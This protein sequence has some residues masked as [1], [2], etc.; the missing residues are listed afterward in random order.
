LKSERA[1]IEFPIWRKK[2]DS[3]IFQYD[4]TA[5]PHWV[6][7]MWNLAED[8][9]QCN[10]KNDPKSK[11]KMI[12]NE[13]EYEGRVVIQIKGRKTPSFRMFYSP[14]LTF[15][16]KDAF[17]MR[18]RFDYLLNEYAR[19]PCSP[20]YWTCSVCPVSSVTTGL[21]VDHSRTSGCMTCFAILVITT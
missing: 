4:G 9:E 6:S 8:F 7:K 21:P 15:E 18:A 12:F 1:D 2:V 16:L 3:S 13:N 11:V 20:P 19:A 5:I 17:V 14:D 10:S